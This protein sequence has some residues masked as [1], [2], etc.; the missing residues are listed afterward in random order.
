MGHGIT[1]QDGMF[2][3]R[4]VPWHGLGEVLSDYPTRQEAQKIAHPWNPVT[5][6]LYRSVPSINDDGE[7][8]QG[9]EEVGTHVGVVRDDTGD[10][11]GVV[12]S[13]YE[14]VSNDTLYDIAETIE[15]QASGS[16]MFETGG[17]LNGGSNVWLLI[18]LRDAISVPGDPNGETIPYYTL[19]N[20]HDGSGSL[21]GQ[22]TQTRVVC[23]NTSRMADF[24]AKRRGTEFVFRHTR[25]V[26]DRIEEAKAALAGWRE[27]LESY[28]QM[29]R[30]LVQEPV[31]VDQR[32][33]FLERMV[34]MPEIA[35]ASDRVRDNVERTRGEF[36]DILD[37][38]TCEGISDTQWGLLAATVEWSQHVRRAQS[39][40]SVLKRTY[41]SRNDVVASAYKI[42]QTI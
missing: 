19:Q 38:V 3:V 42:L 18:R 6:P 21:R 37:G 41:L 7:P 24:E 8:V 9:F 4:E 40:E 30:V 14:V 20:A 15:G 11:I 1:A 34:P 17:S 28:V 25:S 26:H 5:E 22:A 39:R 27:D 29:S 13:G 33:E 23:Q 36:T 16:V 31:T 2:S 32:R 12:G 10:S 35:T